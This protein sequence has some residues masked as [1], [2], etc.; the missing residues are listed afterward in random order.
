MAFLPTKEE[1]RAA[2][3]ANNNSD[4][5][6]KSNGKSNY[7]SNCNGNGDGN[8]QSRSLTTVR[9]R[10]GRVRDDSVGWRSDGRE[11]WNRSAREEGIVA[12]GGLIF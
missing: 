10:R 1:A 9:K 2:A 8:R 5:N 4:S 12:A 7:K 3:T 11:P 6:C